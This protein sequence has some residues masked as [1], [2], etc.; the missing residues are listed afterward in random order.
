MSKDINSFELSQEKLE[1]NTETI[2]AQLTNRQIENPIFYTQNT[3]A[4]LKLSDKLKELDIRG[5]ATKLGITIHGN[6]NAHC[7]NVSYH[8]NNDKNPSL[9]FYNNFQNFKCFTCNINGN[10]IE[11]IKLKNSCNVK[12]AIIWLTKTYPNVF[13]NVVNINKSEYFK[14]D[15]CHK[16]LISHYNNTN[17]TNSIPINYLTKRGIDFQLVTTFKI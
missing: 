12:E 15:K 5:V 8:K 6:V 7:F 17:L 4:I 3:N 11:L 16:Q 9:A 13:H 14:Y 10:I 2:V 1:V